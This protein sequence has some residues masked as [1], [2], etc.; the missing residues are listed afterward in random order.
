ME[1]LGV[2]GALIDGWHEFHR[3]VVEDLARGMDTSPDHP[4]ADLSRELGCGVRGH[5]L[6]TL[7]V[8]LG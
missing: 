8:A 4:P 1:V 3:A 7:T 2:V 6:R 5:L